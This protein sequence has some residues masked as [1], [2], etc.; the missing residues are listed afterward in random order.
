MTDC[1][2]LRKRASAIG[3]MRLWKFVKCVFTAEEVG[4]GEMSAISMSASYRGN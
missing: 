3:G 1:L 2:T 4:D